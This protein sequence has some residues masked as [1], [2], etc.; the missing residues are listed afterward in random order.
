MNLVNLNFYAEGYYSGQTYEE[1]ILITEDFYNKI[2]D[3]VE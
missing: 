2:K 1:N 3:K